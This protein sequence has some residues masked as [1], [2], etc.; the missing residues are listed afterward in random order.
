MG[1]DARGR[2]QGQE[3]EVT[4]LLAAATTGIEAVPD[5]VE[6]HRPHRLNVTRHRAGAVG[7]RDLERHVE[8]AR[9]RVRR[10]DG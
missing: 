6:Q 8:V 4:V 2:H 9:R 7:D 10:H 5:Q 3:H 1:P